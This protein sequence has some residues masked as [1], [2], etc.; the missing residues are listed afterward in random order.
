MIL[1]LVRVCRVAVDSVPVGTFRDGLYFLSVVVEHCG[2]Y[3]YVL[4]D[5]CFE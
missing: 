1:S 2:R 4:Y 3:P 5:E